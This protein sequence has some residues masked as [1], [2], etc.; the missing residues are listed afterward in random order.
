M[1]DDLDD[2]LFDDRPA[3]ALDD[4]APT[5]LFPNVYLFVR[6]HLVHVY[7]RETSKQGSFRW[8]SRWFEHPEAVSRLEA[9]WKAFE[10]LRQDPGV[11]ASSWWR[12]HADP[13]MGALS[14]GQGVFRQCSPGQHVLSDPLPMEEPPEGLLRS[15]GSVENSL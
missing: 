15:G 7:E 5:T 6:D 8:C 4:H 2:D 3:E 10:S 13:V 1:S 14:S 12:D 9:L 11:G